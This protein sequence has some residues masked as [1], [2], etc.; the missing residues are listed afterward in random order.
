MHRTLASFCRRRLAVRGFFGAGLALVLLSVA[1]G[2]ALAAA[3]PTVTAGATETYTVGGSAATLDPG[4]T[5]SDSGSATL[6]SATISEEPFVSGDILNFTDQNGIT[7]SYNATTGTLT[8]SGT[9]SLADYQAA[10][11]SIAFSSVAGDPT[12]GGTDLTRT[13]F[14]SVS[15]AT[16]TSL[17]APS[18]LDVQG[19]T[20]TA[21][22]TGGGGQAN[23]A[24]LYPSISL[25]SST[26]LLESAKVSIVGGFSSGGDQLF[27][28][29]PESAI[30]DLTVTYA[31]GVMTLTAISGSASVAEFQIALQAIKY[32]VSGDVDPTN[33]GI[34]T[35]RRI[36]AITTD[37]N[38]DSALAATATVDTV[39][40][41]PTISAS[42]TPTF[43]NGG[44]A[45][46]LD[47]EFAASDPDSGGTLESATVQI[48]SGLHSG[49]SL[50]FTNTPNIVGSYNG[51][52]GT[53]TL[54]GTDTLA[55]YV[56]ALQSVSYSF[57]GSG[58]PT[59]GGTDTS[60]TITWSVDDGTFDSSPAT[61]TVDVN[62]PPSQLAITSSPLTG[63]GTGT[64][65]GPI[66]VTLEDV[67][68]N[69]VAAAGGGVTVAL[70]SSSADGLFFA[71]HGGAPTTSVT[72]PTGDD[73]ASFYYSDGQT[74]TPKITVAGAS[75]DSAAQTE[76]IDQA[77]AISS[78]DHAVFDTAG[79]STFTVTASGSPTP[80]LTEN[81]SLPHGVTFT[82]NGDGTATLSGTPTS[83][84][85]GTY[86]ITITAAN[87]VSPAATQ[88]FTLTVQD[89]TTTTTTTTQ[90]PPPTAPPSSTTPTPPP[91]T[92]APPATT[93]TPV[94][95]TPPAS[96][97][98]TPTAV[99]ATKISTSTATVTWCHGNGCRFPDTQL[100]F[101]LNQPA[102]V[103]LVLS[104]EVD[105]HWRQ[106][107][108]TSVH[109]HRGSNSYRVAGR[110]HGQLVPVRQVRLQLQLKV[111]GRWQTQ[112][113][114]VLSIRHS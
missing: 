102:A 25:T 12:D 113:L 63:T 99:A 57:S 93:T 81:G 55:N 77:P 9:A 87:G 43:V 97:P 103:K 58:D 23:A 73:T 112:K 6:A 78:T 4:L 65:L 49:D 36:D 94:T 30:P 50:N 74:G 86:N 21:T 101:H 7:G 46:A 38:D 56:A 104:A 41:A 96:T 75:L 22:F 19:P 64:E 39:H 47:P 83:G 40:V 79:A 18:T 67:S 8:L 100:R 62:D 105:G 69:P 89:Q 72:I 3:G 34:D 15:D 48:T 5:V 95:T 98:T 59:S 31:N 13:I 82:D 51:S 11:Q 114:M 68:G 26:G 52:T 71:T 1:A 90:T 70:S 29:L 17:T 111:D 107:A 76:T 2:P 10:L 33:G 61:S 66:T 42:G 24:W 32:Y 27:I 28:D 88:S 108:V 45:V 16:S 106:V 91:T 92:P 53:L 84:S 60:R 37:T 35:S 85:G 109:G 20:S 110:W 14:W 44:T 80:S 54:V